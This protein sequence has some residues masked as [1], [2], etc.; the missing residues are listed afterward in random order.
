MVQATDHKFKKGLEWCWDEQN[1]M[2]TKTCRYKLEN[3]IE[4]FKNAFYDPSLV[5]QLVV[6]WT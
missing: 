1:S 4:E 6:Q 2:N 3:D 5:A